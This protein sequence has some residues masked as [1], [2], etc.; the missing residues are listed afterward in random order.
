MLFQNLETTVLHYYPGNGV[1]T[2]IESKGA[3]INNLVT[4]YSRF[5][6]HTGAP[7]LSFLYTI[8]DFMNLIPEFTIVD[9]LYHVHT[10]NYPVWAGKRL[11]HDPTN[12]IY[13]DNIT[14]LF[15]VVADLISRLDIGIIFG[16][17]GLAVLVI[18]LKR[19]KSKKR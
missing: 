15:Q 18:K 9:N 7:E 8:E 11:V 6:G 5:K 2:A 4:V 17:L 1:T 19:K 16:S 10:E 3:N 12:T 13:F 14:L